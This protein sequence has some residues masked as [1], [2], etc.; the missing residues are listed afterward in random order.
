LCFWQ[1]VFLFTFERK[2]DATFLQGCY[3]FTC[4]SYFGTVGMTRFSSLLSLSLIGLLLPVACGARTDPGVLASSHRQPHAREL[5]DVVASNETEEK[6]W[7]PSSS[8]SSSSPPSPPAAPPAPPR[9]L[10]GILSQ[11][12]YWTGAPA[13]PGG[14]I[15]ASYVKYLEAAGARAVPILFNEANTATLARKFAAVN[16]VLLPGGTIPRR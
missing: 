1:K 6:K 11:P 10:I 8:S 5:G 2:A 4:T 15:A 13:A 9:P 3:F 14:Y 7:F 16:G 12:K